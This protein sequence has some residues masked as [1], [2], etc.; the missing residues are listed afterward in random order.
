[1]ARL[2]ERTQIAR[3]LE[4]EL[5]RLETVRAALAV[6]STLEDADRDPTAEGGGDAHPADLG[7]ELF[8]RERAVSILQRVEAELADVRRAHRRLD[9]GTYGTCEACGATIPIERLAARPAARFCVDDQS[10][11]E[12]ELQA[13]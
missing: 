9:S 11:A 4:A 13:S 8:E 6:E 1:M 12:R 10:R 5:A 2:P 7:S 3:R